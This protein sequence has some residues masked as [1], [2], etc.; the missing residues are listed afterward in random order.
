MSGKKIC[1]AIAL[2]GVEDYAELYMT[3]A[4]PAKMKVKIQIGKTVIF[5]VTETGQEQKFKMSTSIGTP[6]KVLK[7][8]RNEWFA[9]N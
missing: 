8:S 6:V 7:I 4:T 2:H 1:G 9:F 3:T 5:N